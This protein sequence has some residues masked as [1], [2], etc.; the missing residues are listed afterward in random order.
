MRRALGMLVILVVVIAGLA[1][2]NMRRDSGAL[3]FDWQL[4][5]LPPREV[6]V[7]SPS[8]GEIVQTVTAPAKV[9]P[10]EEAEIAS[11]IVGRVVKVNVKDGDS[12]KKGDL[13]VKLDETDARAQ[14]DSALAR[15][16]RYRAAI[17]QSDADREKTQRDVARY[18]NLAGRG[19]ASRTELA[20]AKSLLAKA[21]AALMMSQQ[22]LLDS[23]A[24]RRTSQ[25]YLDRTEI[26]API[27]GVV[28]GLTIE[29]GEV[30]IAGTTN[31][32]GTVMMTVGDLSRM[33]ARAN[34]DETDVPRVRPGQTARVFLQ[35]DLTTPIPGTVDRVAPK[36]KK[37]DEV[38]SFET[39]VN[40]GSGGQALRS[41]MTAT[42]EIEVRRAPNALGIPVQAVAHRRRKDLPD[43][44]AVRLWSERHAKLPG[45]KARDA[46]ARYV[47]VV[48]VL[49]GGV[50]RARPVETGISDERRVE[51]LWGLKT[52]DKVVTGPFRALDEIKDGSPIALAKPADDGEARP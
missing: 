16:E 48:F 12:V 46:E 27:D 37:T 3:Q 49:E 15:I 52:E 24:Q 21:R 39:L 35:S 6:T 14:L 10:V 38:V 25:Q 43:T 7:E 51:I 2:A 40:V 32:P 36:G 23:E 17:N 45:E 42:V 50:A 13:L 9:E 28:A 8:R 30:V 47:K 41:E 26:R 19:V 1:A 22:E 11:Q 4:I 5:K 18:D 31:L 20:D 34:V 33:R 44:A 29:V